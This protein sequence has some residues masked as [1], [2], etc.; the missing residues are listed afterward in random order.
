MSNRQADNLIL[1]FNENGQVRDGYGFN[2]KSPRNFGGGVLPHLLRL[3]KKEY[4][5]DRGGKIQEKT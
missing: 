2:G 3:T 4:K 1:A 5:F